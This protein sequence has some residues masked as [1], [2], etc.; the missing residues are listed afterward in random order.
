V[1]KRYE[2]GGSLGSHYARDPGYSEDIA[3]GGTPVAHKVESGGAEG[4]LA[5]GNG[6]TLGVG[7]GAHVYHARVALLVKV[8]KLGFGGFGH[9]LD[10]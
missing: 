8:G 2:V 3:F 7:L 1:A 9:G 10:A 6:Y 5:C 4:D